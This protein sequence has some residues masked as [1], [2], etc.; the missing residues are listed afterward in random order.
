[1]ADAP[2]VREQPLMPILSVAA[3]LALLTLM[4]GTM[5]A[6]SIAIGAYSALL[7]RN[8]LGSAVITPAW[9]A[10]GGRWPGAAARRVHLRRGL[11][12]AGMTLLFFYGLVR[13]PM[14]EAIA[15][16]FIAP[17]IALYLAAVV[18]GE[19][20]GRRAIGASVLGLVGVIIIGAGRLGGE[21]AHPEAA[22][23][24]AAILGSAVLYAWNLI[25]QRQQAL[26]ARPME[27][28]VFHS[29]VSGLVLAL[30]A[31]WFLRWPDLAT[32][33]TL[34]AAA[35]T[36]LAGAMLLSWGY[37]RAQAQVLVPIEYSGF[38]WAA[39]VGWLFF[40]ETLTVT[41]LTG[42]A[43]IMGACWIA[44]RQRNGRSRR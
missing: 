28:A 40:G 19:T 23:G 6:A 7:V 4:D 9:L 34:A 44:S 11:V 29:G 13:V 32:L 26:L 14:A 30:A 39:L 2:M 22:R 8:A 18:L 20:I 10:L 5:K 43:L 37:A 35:T 25:L 16:S 3:G 21:F 15:L 27:V 12:A 41:T 36:A 1:M 42:A 38:V 24:I 31:P 33:G 17:L